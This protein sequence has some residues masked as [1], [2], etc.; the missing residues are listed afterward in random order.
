MTVV[1]GGGL[2]ENTPLSGRVKLTWVNPTSK[3]A[4]SAYPL[5]NTSSRVGTCCLPSTAIRTSEISDAASFGLSTSEY[6]ACPA[7][8]ELL[9]VLTAVVGSSAARIRS[10]IS[11]GVLGI[12]VGVMFGAACALSPSVS[13]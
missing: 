10:A 6:A 4:R 7:T 5:A 8:I 1:P 9:S 11:C 2:N 13:L 3:A 12:S